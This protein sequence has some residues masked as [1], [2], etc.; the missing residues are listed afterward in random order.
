MKKVFLFAYDH[1]NV[2]D[3]LFIYT[4]TRRYP[5]VQFYLWSL[6]KN[7]ITFR[8]LK[9]LKII[10]QDTGIIS[11]LQKVRPS[12]VARY[13]DWW[14]KQCDAVVYI[15]G[16]I[17]IE[18]PDWKN[19]LNWW[20][21]A[22]S[23]YSLYVL[24]ANFGPYVSEEYKC[25]LEKIFMKMRDVCFRDKYSYKLFYNNSNI[26]YAPDILFSFPLSKE[27]KIVSKQIFL[28]VIDCTRKKEGLYSL[29]EFEKSYIYGMSGLIARF[30]KDGYKVLLSSFCEEEGD[31]EAINKIL[32]TL[33]NIYKNRCDVLSYNGRNMQEILQ[34]IQQ[35]NYI[36]AT[37][38][39]A[40]ILGIVAGRPVFPLVYSDKTIHILQD[41][42]YQGAYF[43]IRIEREYN[44]KIVIENLQKDYVINAKDVICQAK[45]H[46]KKLD[47][48]LF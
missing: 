37:R 45:E 43:D 4:I 30:L 23:N 24:G 13:K 17:F 20:E 47:C 15:G 33:P 42:G 19:I 32:D 41:I 40:V 8:S 7:K 11:L 2:G 3:D 21:Y 44:Y 26:R 34:K 14:C 10:S 6:S 9:N 12:F 28:S 48:L 16:S 18:Y 29:N 1:I 5:N 36:V 27:N 35:S 22:A 31:K 25:Q 39:H 46:F 38:F